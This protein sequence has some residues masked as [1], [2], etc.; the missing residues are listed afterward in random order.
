MC[1]PIGTYKNKF[2]LDLLLMLPGWWFHLGYPVRQD[3]VS[4]SLMHEH[5]W[6]PP[7]SFH[8]KSS[9][10]ETLCSKWKY[11]WLLFLINYPP[12]KDIVGGGIQTHSALFW[13][14]R[15]ALVRGKS[16]LEL[17]ANTFIPDWQP[18]LIFVRLILNLLCMCSKSVDGDYVILK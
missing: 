18:P 15:L 3:K 1:I 12:D 13:G 9:C 4:P 5:Y 11:L 7:P 14:L 6:Q 2:I 10:L 16:L 17:W 8:D